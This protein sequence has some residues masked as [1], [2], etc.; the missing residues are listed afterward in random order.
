MG[1][2]MLR[3]LSMAASYRL[4]RYRPYPLLPNPRLRVCRLVTRLAV[5]RISQDA[6]EDL[7]CVTMRLNWPQHL[8]TARMLEAA[9]DSERGLAL[10]LM[11][12]SLLILAEDL[13]QLE[14]APS[15]QQRIR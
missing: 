14:Q 7:P 9:A 11:G 5:V 3:F 1:A 10:A 13:L 6:H 8:Q 15:S 2:V 12:V 4:Q